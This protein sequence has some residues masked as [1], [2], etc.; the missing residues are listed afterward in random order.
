MTQNDGDLD[1][2]VRRRIRALRLAQGWSL[3]ELAGRAKLSQSTLS[4]IENGQRRLAL[5]SLVTLARALDTT[6][7]QLVETVED[8]IVSNPMIDASRGQLRWPIKADPG[9]TVIRQRMTEPPPDSPSRLRAHPGREWLVVLSGTAVLLLGNRRFRVETN[10]AA[11]FP[12]MLPHAIGAEGGPCEVL[13]IFDRDARRGHQRPD[14]GS[15]QR[16]S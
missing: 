16:R 10:Q 5:D 2:L 14:G 4:R 1:S 7:D 12:T 13:G 9:M 11:E 15:E 3:D 8:D 6:L